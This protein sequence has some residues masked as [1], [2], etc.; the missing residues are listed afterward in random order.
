[1]IGYQWLQWRVGV[2][3]ALDN[4]SYGAMAL[5]VSPSCSYTF[6]RARKCGCMSRI[7]LSHADADEPFRF[8]G[9][10][11]AG[12]ATQVANGRGNLATRINLSPPMPMGIFDSE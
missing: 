8:D 3:P 5:S 7:R 1:M 11:R 4:P 6:P 9:F 2:F 10:V 12:R